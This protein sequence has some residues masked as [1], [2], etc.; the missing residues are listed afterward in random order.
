MDTWD[1]NESKEY[2][3]T[4]I[5]HETFNTEC[6]PDWAEKDLPLTLWVGLVDKYRQDAAG[7]GILAH[8]PY[9]PDCWPY[10]PD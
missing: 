9:C 1:K 2:T 7:C 3:I 6:Q 8:S 4:S 5:E 10:C